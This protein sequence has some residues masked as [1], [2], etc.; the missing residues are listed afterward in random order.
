MVALRTKPRKVSA[1]V[2]EK[3]AI[4]I[5]QAFFAKHSKV[6]EVERSV[7]LMLEEFSEGVSE[8]MAEQLERDIPGMDPNIIKQALEHAKAN[9][10]LLAVK[11]GIVRPG[12]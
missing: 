3:L 12:N 1:A 4:S 9:F 6:S 10:E 7:G 2:R 11:A 8:R 5:I